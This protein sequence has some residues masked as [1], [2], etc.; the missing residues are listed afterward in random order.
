MQKDSVIRSVILV[1]S[2]A[3]WTTTHAQRPDSQGIYRALTKTIATFQHQPPGPELPVGELLRK[4]LS[5]ITD[6]HLKLRHVQFAILSPGTSRGECSE[7][8]SSSRNTSGIVHSWIRG[9]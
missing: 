9:R 6:C 2:L 5:F 8:K 4:H 7:H 1:A 3:V